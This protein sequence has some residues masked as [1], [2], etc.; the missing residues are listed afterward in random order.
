MPKAMIPEGTAKA[1]VSG[2]YGP[3]TWANIMYFAII[4][5]SDDGVQATADDVGSAAIDLYS[6]LSL[7]RFSDQ[8]NVH[9]AKVLYH[10]TGGTFTRVAT[11]ADATGTEDSGDQDAQV[12]YLINW[13]TG[14]VRRGGKPRQY[15]PGV[16]LAACADSA[17]ISATYLGA[18]NSGLVDW[19]TELLDGS[20]PNGSILELV[21]MSFVDGGVDIDPPVIYPVSSGRVNPVVATQ[22][23]RVDRLR[24]I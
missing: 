9:T 3:A 16:P 4:T 19:F 1:V 2:T 10:D 12:A 17:N 6:K 21:E 5:P 11:I 14:D 13:F 22:R 8:F 24:T 15:I 20:L 18:M 7:D 23:R